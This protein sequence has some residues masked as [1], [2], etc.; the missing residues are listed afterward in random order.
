MLKFGSAFSISGCAGWTVHHKYGQQVRHCHLPCPILEGTGP[1]LAEM[2]PGLQRLAPETHQVD[3]SP[4]SPPARR[5]FQEEPSRL[6]GQQRTCNLNQQPTVTLLSQGLFMQTGRNV[7]PLPQ[8]TGREE[9][10]G[11]RW[12]RAAASL[13][14]EAGHSILLELH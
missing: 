12:D 7:I 1:L 3:L 6:T 9:P 2:T 11:L 4:V 5:G 8:R 13:C 14:L 10:C